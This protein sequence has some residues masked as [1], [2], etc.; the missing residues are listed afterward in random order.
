M[1]LKK[2][3]AAGIGGLKNHFDEFISGIKDNFNKY[4]GQESS[5]VDEE[6]L[7]RDI[8]PAPMYYSTDEEY[9][10]V[11]TSFGYAP[12][13]SGVKRDETTGAFLL[14]FASPD[15]FKS[16]PEALLAR[17]FKTKEEAEVF[18]K[19]YKLNLA[20]YLM[21]TEADIKCRQPAVAAKMKADYFYYNDVNQIYAS[22]RIE[23]NGD[24]VSIVVNNVVMPWLTDEQ[25]KKHITQ[26]M[27]SRQSDRGLDFDIPFCG[28]SVAG[29]ILPLVYGQNYAPTL[30]HDETASLYNYLK[31]DMIYGFN[32]SKVINDLL[33]SAIGNFDDYKVFSHYAPNGNDKIYKNAGQNMTDI[34]K[35]VYDILNIVGAMKPIDIDMHLYRGAR[36]ADF[37]RSIPESFGYDGAEHD[38]DLKGITSASTSRSGAEHYSSGLLF[39]ISVPKG[40][41]LLWIALMQ[42]LRYDGKTADNEVIL[43]PMKYKIKKIQE[44]AKNYMEPGPKVRTVELEGT[45]A[46]DTHDALLQSLNR[47][48]LCNQHHPEIM[49]QI[50]ECI[51]M[52]NSHAKQ[53]AKG[54]SKRKKEK[55]S[56]VSLG[57]TGQ[58]YAYKKLGKQ[59]LFKP[60]LARN[61]GE[62]LPYRANI[63]EAAYYVQS[64]VDK[65]SA[66]PCFADTKDGM[67][68]AS[69]QRIETQHADM[70]TV[71]LRQP[72]ADILNQILREFVVDYLLNNYDAHPNNFI[73]GTDGI[74]RGIDKE[75]SFKFSAESE[76]QKP[77]INYHPNKA[78]GEAEPVYNTLFQKYIKEPTFSLDFSQLEQY[79][80]RVEDVPTASYMKAFKEYIG[81]FRETNPMIEE[82]I[83]SKKTNIRTE[84]HDFINDIIRQSGRN[85]E[86]GFS[87]VNSKDSSNARI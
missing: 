13:P 32:G 9:G 46:I 22:R 52:V 31:N 24:N 62:K 15:F 86:V 34:K 77:S 14:N 81:Y 19:N 12:F 3:L 61:T 4:I 33:W 29:A 60:A 59:Y 79:I 30:S 51:S 43:P 25:A 80:S 48:K 45:Q 55:L 20:A 26:K 1:N 49:S 39:D 70:R 44:K 53:M 85:T 54:G 83:K 69:Q 67:F 10:H 11:Q 87:K 74:L 28:S 84:L 16:V 42:N 71:M 38:I 5:I 76:A 6:S 21:E 66:V 35:A 63:Q 7:F 17:T 23:A 64:I 36:A 18:I 2:K 73:L 56:Q 58:M 68:G 78:H 27:A 82:F 57:G 75:Q 47:I 72:S 40:A 65:K 41:P 8:S 50:D 37:S